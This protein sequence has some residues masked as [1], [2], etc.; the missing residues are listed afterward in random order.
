[1]PAQRPKNEDNQ[2]DGVITAEVPPPRR[3]LLEADARL[4]RLEEKYCFTLRAGIEQRFAGEAPGGYRVDLNYV[5]ERKSVEFVGDQ[6]DL[7]SSRRHLESA[8]LLSGSDWVFL[9]S[10]GVA[11]FDSRFTLVLPKQPDDTTPCMV[12]G[13]VR[14]RVDL[15]NV[16]DGH[17]APV[18][19]DAD[20]DGA[21]IIRKWKAGFGAGSYVPMLVSVTFDVPIAGFNREQTE[22]YGECEELGQGTFLGVGCARY[23]DGE[24]SPVVTLNLALYRLSA[25]LYQ[26]FNGTKWAVG[27]A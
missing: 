12:E 24:K 10:R 2:K 13:R 9:N 26:S 22:V 14:G 25:D 27:G 7:G 15:R 11:A 1:M 4:P 8:R 6:S 23:D 17:G 16:C 5:G 3:T 20:P 21:T 18:F 19:D